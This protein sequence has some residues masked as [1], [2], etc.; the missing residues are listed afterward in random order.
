MKSSFAARS[1][2]VSLAFLVLALAGCG[3]GGSSTPAQPQAALTITPSSV[4]VQLGGQ[5]QFSAAFGIPG[6][7]TPATVTW[8]VGGVQ[9]GNA[10]VGTISAAGL[11]TAPNSF[12][13]TNPVSVTATLQSNAAQ[14]G[15]ASVSVGF[16]SGT[17]SSQAAPIKLG[18]S[19][20]NSK[21]STVNNTNNT[22]TCC[23]GTLGALVKRGANFY[24]LSN[25]HVLA[26]SDRGTAGDPITQPGLV[27]NNCRSGFQVATLN[28]FTP[29]NSASAGFKNVDAALGLIVAGTVDTSGAI[30]DLGTPG[31]TSVGAAP[32]SV[33][34]F[35]GI[36]PIGTNLAKVGRTT[37]LTCATLSSIQSVQ[38]KYETTCGSNVT[39][40]TST[41]TNQL[42]INGASFSN[43]GDSGSLV[44]D[45][46]TSRAVGLLYGGDTTST[47]AH[48]IGD[49]FTALTTA[50][51]TPAIVGG[52]D[53]AVSCVPMAPGAASPANDVSTLGATEVE[54]ARGAREAA[55]TQL[56]DPS[57]SRVEIGHSAD[58]PNE[59]AVLVYVDSSSKMA[60][61]ATIQGVR[62]RV[63][64]DNPDGTKLTLSK[65]DFDRGMALKDKYVETMLGEQG[66][67]GVGVAMSDDNPGEPAIIISVD[68]SLGHQQ[69]PT[70][71]DG[72]RTKIVEAEPYKSFD[73]NH[74]LEP[75]V[76]GCPKPEIHKKNVTLNV[77]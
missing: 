54:R 39:A 76:V 56:S 27:D 52:A 2:I 21:D 31:T 4:V 16:P 1:I 10:T 25:N 69:F 35:N 14:V 32:P 49:V 57:I 74:S 43:S 68:Q 33:T 29:V 42:I 12:P 44:V 45:A 73:W 22:I 46:A 71:L 15:S 65:A 36:P 8:S 19:G 26:E 77:K 9:G 6:S 47:T 48:P 28:T 60:L 53:H 38:I 23:S 75:K 30:L 13:A 61:P 59:S 17:K 58:N 55:M 11:Y 64:R 72:M 41:F 66:V 24:V 37:G 70:V 34:A 63:I 20:G 40:F 67:F 18:T 51:G 50:E 5:Q 62:T 7:Q 3:G